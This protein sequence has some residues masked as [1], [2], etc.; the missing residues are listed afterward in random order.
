MEISDPKII[1]GVIAAVSAIIGATIGAYSKAVSSKQKIN[2]IKESYNQKLQDNYLEKAREYTESVYIP[3]SILLSHLS[4][5]FKTYRAHTTIENEAEIKQELITA[6][7]EFLSSVNDLSSRGAGAFLTAELDEKLQSFCSFL[8]ESSSADVPT[9]KMIIG[10]SLPFLGSAYKDE[11]E[12]KMSGKFA[13]SL[14]S[15][16]MSI[17]LG[18]LGL[19]YEAKEILA[20]PIGS[21]DFEERFVR[22]S[23]VIN[24]LIKEVTLGAK[25]K[26]SLE[27]AQR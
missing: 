13:R 3:L 10:F 24:V 6:I 23:H 18:G 27:S 9:L 2:E 21:R 25:A 7:N 16:R 5:N 4:Y 14:W 1:A 11:V 22:D 8:N 15:P 26:H 17:S 19:S 12:K 20:A